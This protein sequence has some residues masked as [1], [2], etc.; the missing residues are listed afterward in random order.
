MRSLRI[1]LVMSVLALSPEQAAT[2]VAGKDPALSAAIG[3]AA[4]AARL[5]QPSNA[6]RFEALTALLRERGVK[7]EVQAFPNERKERDPRE[8]GQ[9]VIVTLGSAAREIVIGA[10]FDAVHLRDGKLSHGM[11]DNAAG[12]IA[13]TRVAEVLRARPLKHRVHIVFFD[14]EETGLL[15]SAHYAKSL[16]K[17]KVAAAV[18]VDVAGYG[19]TL[20]FGPGKNEG[21]AEVYGAMW[22]TC[23]EQR[24]TCVEFPEFPNGDD[25][26]FQAAGIPNLSLAILPAVEAHQLWLLLNAGRGSGLAE[27]FVIPILD[28]I[29]TP[30]DTAEKL[31]SAAMARVADAVVSLILELDK[32]PD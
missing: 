18:N 4:D 8:Q 12:A 21:N 5:D 19:D 25:R 14:M 15:G 3:L 31:D 7:F 13:L 26:S 32:L 2:D 16:D 1:A 23:A 27:G 29:H 6:A 24:F 28:V 17:A 30:A 22:R 10:H 20:I 9:N 11:V